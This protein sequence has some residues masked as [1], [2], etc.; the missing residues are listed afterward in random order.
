MLDWHQGVSLLFTSREFPTVPQTLELSQPMAPH[1]IVTLDELSHVGLACRMLEASCG[2]P[3][4]PELAS[5]STAGKFRFTICCSG[6]LAAQ[7][8]TDAT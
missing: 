1:P 8:V 6:N 7:D 5:F 3:N 2:Q 4:D